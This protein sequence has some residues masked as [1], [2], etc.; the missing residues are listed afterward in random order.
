MSTNM[1]GIFVTAPGNLAYY[2]EWGENSKKAGISING[3]K[4]YKLYVY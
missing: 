2:T 1:L 3:G 4:K